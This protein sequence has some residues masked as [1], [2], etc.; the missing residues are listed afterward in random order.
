MLRCVSARSVVRWLMM[1][2]SFENV[3]KRN[4]LS[5]DVE[6]LITACIVAN[7]SSSQDENYEAI[8]L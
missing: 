4:T 5:V 8:L 3:V 1:P 7:S 6:E 2:S